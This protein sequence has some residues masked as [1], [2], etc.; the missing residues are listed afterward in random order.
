MKQTIFHWLSGFAWLAGVACGG[1]IE[2]TGDDFA[3]T[4]QALDQIGQ[5]CMDRADGL[6]TCRPSGTSIRDLIDAAGSCT[7][8][9][10]VDELYPAP[11]VGM[12]LDEAIRST[13]VLDQMIRDTNAIISYTRSNWSGEHYANLIGGKLRAVL[14]QLNNAQDNA[15]NKR[16]PRIEKPLEDFEKKFVETYHAEIDP[17]SADLSDSKR[18]IERINEVVAKSL[19]DFQPLKARYAQIASRF[20]TYRTTES[21]LVTDLTDISRRASQAELLDLPAI[22]QELLS[23]SSRKRAAADELALEATRLA[24]HI[25]QLEAVYQRRSEPHVA[26][27]DRHLS[28][29]PDMTGG[30]VKSL[31]N[32]VSYCDQRR[33]QID[34]QVARLFRGLTARRDGLIALAADERTRETM[35]HAAHLKASSTFLN[36]ATARSSELNKLPERTARYGLYLW[37]DKYD[38]NLAVL[39]LE[40]LCTAPDTGAVP[41]WRDSGCV[42][43]KRIFNR[44]RT[45]VTTAIGRTIRLAVS[46]LRSKGVAE[47]IL[48]EILVDLDAGRVRRAAVTYDTAARL[49]EV[50]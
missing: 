47:S 5:V 10:W 49:T 15:I 9:C 43:Y 6:V 16:H 32:M 17:L 29:I 28:A 34:A 18:A 38:Q 19:S 33:L 25:A 30:A 36:E 13:V 42:A 14:I 46:Q 22:S 31:R 35:R 7:D 44:A 27:I 4:S 3:T 12:A 50:M 41:S 39:E 21:S 11:P 26:F 8:R 23:Y 24:S 48:S 45:N 2:S 40:P 20:Q 37:A 1:P